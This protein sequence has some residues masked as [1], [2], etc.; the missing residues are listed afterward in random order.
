MRW[1]IAHHRPER[2]AE[3]LQTLA[4]IASA[5]SVSERLLFTLLNHLFSTHRPQVT[6]KQ[7]Q[8]DRIGC[9][10]RKCFLTARL[11]HRVECCDSIHRFKQFPV[12][13]Q[14]RHFN[15]GRLERAIR[16]NYG[17]DWRAV[18]GLDDFEQVSAVA[19]GEDHQQIDVANH[20]DVS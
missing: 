8:K 4:R 13:S 14:S 11:V 19:G 10:E 1:I 3:L 7:K 20:I 16:S 15:L 12:E 17:A 6:S 2:F 5:G 9:V 18:C